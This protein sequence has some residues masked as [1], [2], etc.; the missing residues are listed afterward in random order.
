MLKSIVKI[1]FSFKERGETLE[2]Q[3]KLKLANVADC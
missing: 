2:T 3:K 1:K